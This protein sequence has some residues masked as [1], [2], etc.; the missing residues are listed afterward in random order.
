MT[1][2]LNAFH[3]FMGA[4]LLGAVCC[5]TFH[6]AE[7][8][9]PTIKPRL[10]PDSVEVQATCMSTDPWE[11]HAR[12]IVI[13]LHGSGVPL[14]HF[15]VVTAEHILAEP[16]A[17]MHNLLVKCPTVPDVHVV[18][19][20]GRRIRAYPELENIDGDVAVLK[21]V[22]DTG[23]DPP[24]LRRPVVGEIVCTSVSVPEVQHNCGPVQDLSGEPG[25]DFHVLDD[26]MSQSGNSGGGVWGSDGTL[27]GLLTRGPREDHPGEFGGTTSIP[28]MPGSGAVGAH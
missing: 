12:P 1:H 19:P 3:L 27:V 4:A 7:P 21:T 24:P 6:P 18:F 16:T 13:P 23:F 22:E 10:N 9:S 11:T 8:N 17:L 15:H 2:R 26:G 28:G 14:D 20:D 25:A 5:H